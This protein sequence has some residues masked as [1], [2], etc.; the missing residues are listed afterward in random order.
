MPI[1]RLIMYIVTGALLDQILAS[2]NSFALSV[3]A[4]QRVITLLHM[5]GLVYVDVVVSTTI[6]TFQI[7]FVCFS[8]L[9]TPLLPNFHLPLPC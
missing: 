9:E 1:A 7:V 2:A 5:D 3:M 6:P 8:I 4:F